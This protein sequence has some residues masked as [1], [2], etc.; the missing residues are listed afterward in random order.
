MKT[1]TDERVTAATNT[2]LDL[3]R[4]P[5]ALP[6]TIARVFLCPPPLGAPSAK[7]SFRNRVI[8]AKKLTSDARGFKAWKDAGTPVAKG[9]K[10]FYI[11]AP[12]TKK[13]TDKATGEDKIVCFAFKP[14]PVFRTEDTQGGP[15]DSV[16]VRKYIDALPLVEVARGW[17]LEVK[18]FTGGV[19]AGYYK[20][21]KEIALSDNSLQ[22]WAHELMHAAD[23]K[24]GNLKEAGQHWRKEVVAEF[25]GA[26]LLAALGLEHKWEL[27][28]SYRYV[29]AYAKEADL[30]VERATMK[31]L[32]RIGQA[33]A[34]ILNTAAELEKTTAA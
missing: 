24:A 22:T 31:C 18:A 17:G 26:A 20:H 19:A 14:I 21:G 5:D 15:V 12:C 11:L 13:V 33:M 8:M 16:E 1:K 27:K 10:A 30:T 23:H 25:G 4:E 34:L 2:I 29:E 6:E 28:D 9:A 7:W 32:D 3:F